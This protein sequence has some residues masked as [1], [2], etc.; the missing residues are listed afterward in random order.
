MPVRVAIRKAGE[1]QY[2]FVLLS[3]TGTVV[4]RSETFRRKSE[5]RR[6][7]DLVADA[8]NPDATIEDETGEVAE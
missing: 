3:E 8:G 6:A 7:I 4:M 5:A 2:Y 1:R